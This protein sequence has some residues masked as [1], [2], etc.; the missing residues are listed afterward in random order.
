MV[1]EPSRAEGGAQGADSRAE[2]A[3]EVEGGHLGRLAE[4]G[5]D[6]GRVGLVQVGRG[7]GRQP[8]GARGNGRDGPHGQA[9]RLDPHG[10]R[11]LVVGG[12]RSAALAAA[13]AE[14]TGHLGPL[15][16]TVGHVPGDADDPPGHPALPVG[17]G[18]LMVGAIPLLLVCPAAPGAGVL[19]A[20]PTG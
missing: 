12:H 16:P 13:S 15:E 8:D 3:S 14:D 19:R 20:R 2:G 9:C 17:C 4:R 6:A 10:G 1:V 18:W 11:V 7:G 5:V